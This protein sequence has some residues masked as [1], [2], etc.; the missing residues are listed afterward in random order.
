[1]EG[2]A[3][4]TENAK[5]LVEAIRTGDRPTVESLLNAEPGLL[6]FKTPN[7][8]SVMLLAAYYGQAKLADVFIR[9]GAKP[10]IFEACALGDLDAARN[11]VGANAALVNAFA[12]DGFYPLGLAAFFGH[13][14][15]VE[16]LLK[17]G[18]E[19]SMAA[20]NPQKVTAL[21]GAV[22]RRDLKIAKLL[23]NAGANPNAR[24]ER[25]FAPLH[26]AAANGSVPLVE[27]LVQHG[28][29]PDAKADDGKTP[30]DMAAER[31]HNEVVHLL[32]NAT[33]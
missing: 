29:Q 3:A 15:I 18:A 22:A 20:R 19:V 32:R 26:D 27:L 9:R 14:E 21:H 31:S 13:L 8:S 4:M 6:D 2:A 28:A 24:Q 1:M 25:G 7:G 33:S 30:A 17:N 5:K 12:P 10:N 23:L 16:F 11:L